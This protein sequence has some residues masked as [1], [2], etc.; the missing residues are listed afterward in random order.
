M[1]RRRVAE[2]EAEQKLQKSS[3][4]LER[5]EARFQEALLTIKRRNEAALRQVDDLPSVRSSLEQALQTA[6]R[7]LETIAQLI[8]MEQGKQTF[9][10]FNAH[11]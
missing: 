11:Q 1:M 9:H 3:E 8:S 10:R 7:A 2:L 6:D 5:S 4:T